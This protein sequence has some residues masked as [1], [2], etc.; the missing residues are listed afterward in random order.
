MPKYIGEMIDIIVKAS[1]KV[2]KYHWRN[3]SV[4]DNFI[5]DVWSKQHITTSYPVIIIDPLQVCLGFTA[6]FPFH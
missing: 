2:T 6:L 4:P 3:G 1:P 5:T